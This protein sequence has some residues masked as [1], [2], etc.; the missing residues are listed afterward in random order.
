VLFVVELIEVLLYA[1]IGLGSV[2][3]AKASLSVAAQLNRG[4]ERAGRYARIIRPTQ[5]G[6]GCGATWASLLHSGRALRSVR[7]LTWNCPSFQIL[8]G[9]ISGCLEQILAPSVYL[10]PECGQF[11]D[12]S[13]SNAFGATCKWPRSCLCLS[14]PLGVP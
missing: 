7:L 3:P 9:Q 13:F 14:C 2:G 12:T 6:L 5:F 1:L 4:F 8:Q 11:F 10:R